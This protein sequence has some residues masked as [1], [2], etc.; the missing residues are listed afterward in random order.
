MDMTPLAE[1]ANVTYAIVGSGKALH[2]SP[3][4]DETL[5]HREIRAY[6]DLAEACELLDEQGMKMCKLCFRA[7][8]KRAAEREA[9]ITPD[10]EREQIAALGA[11]QT[12]EAAV[13]LMRSTRHLGTRADAA[14][15]AGKLYRSLND[16]ARAALP[17]QLADTLDTINRTDSEL[18]LVN[19]SNRAV[20][21]WD[22]QPAIEQQAVAADIPSDTWT[23]TTRNGEEIARV[24]GAT[25]EDMTRAAE[26]LPAV[27]A[28][29]KREGGFARR[30][31]YTSELLPADTEQRVVEGVVV[32]HSGTAEGCA[33][34][35]AAHPDV[36]A[37]REALA[38]LAA[39]T[40]TEHHDVTEPTEDEQTVRG[41]LIDP[42][43][44]GRVA[45]YWLEGGRIIRRDQMPHG[46][47]LDCLADRLRRRGWAVEKMLRSSQC[48]FAHLPTEG[49][50]PAPQTT[51]A[52]V[53]PAPAECLHRVAVR[54]DV[55][56]DPI[57]ACV[58]MQ[59][60]QDAGVFS[61]EGCVEAYD[62]AVQ[63]AN[64][65]AE[66]NAEEDAPASDPVYAWDL[67]CVEHRDSE[68]QIDTCEECNAAE[69]QPDATAAELLDTV[70]AIE[71]AERVDGTW[72]GGWIAGTTTPADELLFT[73]DPADVEQGAL[74]I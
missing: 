36:V 48:V 53:E 52:A 19:L 30:R 27:R 26:A 25:V 50:A 9:A 23:I 7:G 69:N 68:Q 32:A 43:T 28:N 24:E 38:G 42:R 31:L 29:I 14:R 35:D 44:H 41:Y 49:G 73:L 10:V 74:F 18:S 55:S 70:D 21:L 64:R 4:N 37:A 51:A 34:A 1:R 6:I 2:F 63:A 17:P 54:P 11:P 40:M 8:Q 58:R 66:M 33:P 46:P 13:E 56:G 20:E 5:C 57:K 65:A 39:A 71:K 15:A 12:V 72:H 60:T 59:P 3:R 62:C 22:E 47:A 16:A 45:V 67:L 61:D